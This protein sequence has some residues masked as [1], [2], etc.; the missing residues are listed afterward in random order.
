MKKAT[1]QQEQQ[2]KP[3]SPSLKSLNIL[4][5]LTWFWNLERIEGFDCV[6]RV[7]S[8]LLYWMRRV[9]CLDGLN[10]GGWGGIYSPNHYSSRWLNSLS[11]GTSDSPVVHRTQP[12]S[13]SGACHVYRPLGFG[14]VDRWSRLSFCCTGQFSAT[15]HRRLSSDFWRYRLRAQSH[16]RPLGEVDRCL[17]SHRTVQWH[18]G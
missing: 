10:G 14:A 12:C 1:K 3:K 4:D 16:S 2:K 18:T 15:C 11:M 5:H 9:G 7:Y 17:L 13:L 8:L 6:F